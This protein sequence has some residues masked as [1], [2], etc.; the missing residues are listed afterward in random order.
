MNVAIRSGGLRVRGDV[1]IFKFTEKASED[2]SKIVLVP[3][4]SRLASA[5]KLSLYRF[6]FVNLKMRQETLPSPG[7]IVTRRGVLQ[8]GG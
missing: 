4:T 5:D 8:S 6:L 2:A 3:K 7:S 1:H